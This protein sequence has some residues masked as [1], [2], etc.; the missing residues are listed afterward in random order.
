M[1]PIYIPVTLRTP[2]GARP[3]RLVLGLQQHSLQV[4]LLDG[5]GDLLPTSQRAVSLGALAT[6][7]ELDP[8]ICE[9]KH[10]GHKR[11]SCNSQPP[12]GL[13]MLAVLWPK[14]LFCLF[15]L[16]EGDCNCATLQI[17]NIKKKWHYSMF[18]NCSSPEKKKNGA[19]TFPL[20]EVVN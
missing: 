16:I 15:V 12:A 7:V 5:M 13:R 20:I 14:L 19:F 10:S 17:G 4:A 8:G 11:F 9:S 18:S 2:F 6:E 3:A 1:P